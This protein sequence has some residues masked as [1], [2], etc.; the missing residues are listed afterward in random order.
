MDTDACERL[1]CP[2]PHHFGFRPNA[3]YWLKL[4]YVQRYITGWE[5]EP[6]I[7]HSHESL[8]EP[9][10]VYAGRITRPGAEIRRLD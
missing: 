1:R 8:M 6:S 3:I 4:R 10:R 9:S 5:I 2:N 7:G